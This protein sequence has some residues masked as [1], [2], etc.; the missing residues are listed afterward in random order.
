MNGAPDAEQPQF[1]Q[2][3]PAEPADVGG[4]LKLATFNVLNYF[5]TLGVDYD[6]GPGTCSS[7]V[8]RDGNPIAVNSCD[9]DGP[10]GA[11]NAASF[12]RQQ[13]KIVNAI[14]TM[15]ADIVS[16]EEIENS[17][18]VDD[19]PNRDEAVGALV[20][21][22]N[23]AAGSTRW[24][25]VPSP[26]EADLPPEAEED[27]IRTAFIYNP[28]TVALVGTSQILTGVPA[29]ANAREP[30]AQAFK[31]KTAA[32]EDGFAVVVN[33][34]K[35]KGERCRRRH[36]PGPGQ[37]GPGRRRR[38]PSTPSPTTSRP[39]EASTRPS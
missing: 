2:D 10:R 11:W 29:F 22:L 18:K 30:L 13:A 33:H 23:A 8:D 17:R 26:A 24:A 14:N 32:D 39:R 31:A 5:T 21:A 36:W 25:F 38:R 15:D 27:V 35:S 6:A 9:G 4:N 16:L 7:F 28:D 12:Q 19:I 1:E 34:F 20:A 3:R 37:P